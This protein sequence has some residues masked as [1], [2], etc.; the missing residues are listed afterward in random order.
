MMCINGHDL[1]QSQYLAKNLHYL[2]PVVTL[3]AY[4]LISDEIIPENFIFGDFLF[5]F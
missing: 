3:G 4:V 1:H 2:Q 5:R